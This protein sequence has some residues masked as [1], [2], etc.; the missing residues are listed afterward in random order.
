MAPSC[1]KAPSY[2]DA[3]RLAV[4]GCVL[5]VFFAAAGI[6]GYMVRKG[7]VCGGR[8]RTKS[9]FSAREILMRRL[10]STEIIR[11]QGKVLGALIWDQNED[12]CLPC[13][14]GCEL[15]TACL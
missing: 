10:D 3:Y 8:C 2:K 7:T 14:C 1:W 9:L 11:F 13:S 6:A 12:M 4:L 15:C 5:E